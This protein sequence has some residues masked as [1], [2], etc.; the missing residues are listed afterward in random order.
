[1]LRVH[2]YAMFQ[3]HTRQNVG[4]S[5]FEFVT[6]QAGADE[7]CHADLAVQ[8]P[9]HNH[10]TFQSYERRRNIK[11]NSR[12]IHSRCKQNE[13]LLDYNENCGLLDAD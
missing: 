2:K 1:M 8:Q 7:L 10:N 11:R 13:T 12:D 9:L 3:K 6:W 4:E 5:I